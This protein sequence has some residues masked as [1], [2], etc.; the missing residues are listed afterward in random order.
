MADIHLA[1]RREAMP[2]L[3]RSH[4][5]DETRSWFASAVGD[6]PARWWVARC[7]GRLVGY[8]LI[9]EKTWITCMSY[10]VGKGVGSDGRYS[11][12]QKS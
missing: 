5:D 6:Q 4:S 9:H 11:T 12:R 8:M 1:A 7:E 10:L 3:H 2:F